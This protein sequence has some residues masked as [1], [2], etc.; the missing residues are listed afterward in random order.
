MGHWESPY[1]KK[2]AGIR[3]LSTMFVDAAVSCSAITQS[4]KMN[5]SDQLNQFVNQFA[6]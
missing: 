1:E 5:P 4:N 3:G 2:P 6:G